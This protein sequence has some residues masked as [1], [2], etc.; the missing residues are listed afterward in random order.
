MASVEDRILIAGAGPIGMTAAA[1]LAQNG[2][3]VTVLEAGDALSKESRAS[4]F[5]PSTLDMLHASGVTAELEEHGLRAPFLQYRSQDEGVLARFNFGDISDLTQ[6]PYR[7][8]CEQ[9]H[10]TRILMERL[11]NLPNFEIAFNHVVKAVEQTD[12]SVSVTASCNGQT[13]KRTGRWLIGADGASSNVRSATGIEFEGFTW[14]D[15]FLVL[16]TP[17]D[18][19]EHIPDLDLVSYVA[20]PVQWHFFLRIP[21][22]W[23]VMVPVSPEA[24]DDEV[25]GSDYGKRC[26]ERV[27]P[28]SGAAPIHH[29]TLY[30]VHQ[31]VAK[32]FRHGRVFLAGDAAHI[33]N[34]LGGMGMNGGIHDAVNVT[35]ILRAIWDRPA[36]AEHLDRYERQRRAVT[37]QAVQKHTIQNKKDLESA[38]EAD[39]ASFRARLQAALD[40]R[41][42]MRAFLQRLAMITSLK[43]AAAIT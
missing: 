32:R 13:V 35:N 2:V 39:R 7:L 42:E 40:D 6:H 3:P 10:L 38:T 21:G 11:Q 12:Q 36:T 4:T 14:A 37:L 5:H 27:L 19:A 25:L 43:Q 18:Y 8:Q 1:C 22:L 15:R 34:P 29:R 17:F 26:L 41:G 31:R 16:S 28:G 24:S 20:D 9:W 23:R 33:N 30:R